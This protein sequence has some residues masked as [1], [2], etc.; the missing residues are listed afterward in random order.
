MLRQVA[1]CVAW[2][3]VGLLVSV[4]SA[5]A[6]EEA[7]AVVE[8]G[9]TVGIEYEITL[10]DGT[11]V[12]TSEGGE[13]L[14]YVHGTGQMF[15]TLE[16]ALSG[17]RVDESKKVTL[18][19]EQGFGPVDPTL[20]QEVAASAVPEEARKAGTELVSEDQAGQR[21][22][23]RVKEVHGDTILIDLNHPLASETLH[24]DVKV[25]SID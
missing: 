2:F 5:P 18:T 23:V 7:S 10:D 24:F 19:P 14:S 12:D 6:Q 1:W 16:E 21:R 20:V 8:K 17:M 22:I 11:V 3:V 13:P 15:P 4:S 9:K 25:V